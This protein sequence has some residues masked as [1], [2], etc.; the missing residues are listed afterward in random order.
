LLYSLYINKNSIRGAIA[1]KQSQSESEQLVTAEG[2]QD[3]FLAFNQLSDQLSQSYQSLQDQVAT[4]NDE[5]QASHSARIEELTEK[6]RLAQRL[7]TL[8]AAL[9]GGV[10]V[11]DG[12][13]RVQEYNPAAV[14]LLGEPL[15]NQSWAAVIQRA[16]APRPDD[17][18][19]ISLLSGRRVTISTCPMGSEPGQILLL[20]DVTE[21]RQL[22]DRL[23]HQQRLASM[24]EMAASLAHQIRTPL[25]SALLYSSNL[26]RQKLDD[27]A[28]L[29]FSGKIFERLRYLESLV[30]DMLLFARGEKIDQQP[31]LITELLVDIENQLDARLSAS[32]TQL[33]VSNNCQQALVSG[34]P[35]MLSSAILNLVDNAIQAMSQA[36]Q[37]QSQIT[38]RAECE[39]QDILIA[40]EDNGPGI[41]LDKQQEVFNPFFTTRSDGTGLGLAVVKAI[42]HAH[43]GSIDLHSQPGEGC[44]FTICLPRLV[45]S[46][47]DNGTQSFESNLQ[48]VTG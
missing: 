47:A 46:K 2:L 36:E 15:Q 30:N 27:E 41:A 37:A 40:I 38:M 33:A 43:Q 29:R 25:A 26:K 8:L 39:A 3:A 11:L 34:N 13:G 10:I 1:L 18:H 12:E 42:I 24:G 17:G 16:F 35:K 5:L 28:R 44:T 48:T 7:Q 6:E 19:E 45:G 4:L 9:P 21:M 23:N 20:T 14:R 31:V 32:Q 22:Q